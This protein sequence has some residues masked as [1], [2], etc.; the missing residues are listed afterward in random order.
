MDNFDVVWDFLPHI[1]LYQTVLLFASSSF[2]IIGGFWVLWIVFGF[3]KPEVRCLNAL[4]EV[5]EANFT[6][7][8][9]KEFLAVPSDQEWVTTEINLCLSI[10]QTR[11]N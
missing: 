2:A 10:N 6:W 1:T 8:E 7:S 11:P 3:Y 4:D 9:I 5:E